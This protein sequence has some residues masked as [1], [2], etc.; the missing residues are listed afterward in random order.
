[1]AIVTI[2]VIS[3]VTIRT[4]PGWRRPGSQRLVL[5]GLLAVYQGKHLDGGLNMM[6]PLKLGG[7]HSL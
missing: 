3:L 2:L 1:M 7:F 4:T 5:R 6:K